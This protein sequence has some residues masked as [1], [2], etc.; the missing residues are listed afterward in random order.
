MIFYNLFVAT[1]EM[2]VD[3]VFTFFT[4][5]FSSFGVI[6]A[7][8]GVSLVINFLALPIYN[9]ADAL[10]ARRSAKRMEPQ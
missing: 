4:I 9:V 1:I 3:W 5:K 7:I 2:V 8:F 10:Q 6:G